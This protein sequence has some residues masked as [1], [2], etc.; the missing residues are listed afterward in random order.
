MRLD[1]ND[2]SVESKFVWYWL[3]SSIAREFIERKA[4]GTSPTMKKITQGIVMEIPF[5]SSLSL[6]RQRQIVADLDALQAKID[7]LKRLQTETTT[8]LDALLPSVLSKA[9]AGEL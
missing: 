5:P 3:Q 8:E 9:F 1:L 4:K 6:S 7:E 2:S